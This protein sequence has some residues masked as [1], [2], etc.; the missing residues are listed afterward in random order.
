MK[1]TTFEY[2][3]ELQAR[4]LADA[5]MMLRPGVPRQEAKRRMRAK[6]RERAAWV[7]MVRNINGSMAQAKRSFAKF[8]RAYAKAARRWNSVP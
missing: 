8:G 5:Y 1:D 3:V 6:A 7:R 4:L 2:E